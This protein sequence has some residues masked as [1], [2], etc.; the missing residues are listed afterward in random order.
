[1][2][3]SASQT[4]ETFLFA[5]GACSDLSLHCTSVVC[6]LG[7]ILFILDSDIKS[8]MGYLL[9]RL[10]LKK[11]YGV[12]ILPQTQLVAVFVSLKN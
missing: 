12:G 9:L 6:I 3:L 2:S 8:E 7:V 5:V 11:Q 4:P 10:L 1:M